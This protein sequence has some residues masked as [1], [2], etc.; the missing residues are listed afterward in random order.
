MLF[1]STVLNNSGQL[2]K[3][4]N[5]LSHCYSI[6]WDHIELSGMGQIIKSL[7]S[8]CMSVLLSVT[9]CLSVTTPTVAILIQ[10]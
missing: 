6:A 5:Y 10:F 2:H 9:V 1:S 3:E 4:C 7:A 8:V